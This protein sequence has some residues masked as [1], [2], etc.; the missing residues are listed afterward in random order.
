LLKI[1]LLTFFSNNQ[2]A[3]VQPSFC[4]INSQ[5]YKIS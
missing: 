2:E 5:F 1:L 3:P 4:F